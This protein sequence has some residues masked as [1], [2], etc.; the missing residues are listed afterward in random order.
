MRS[1]ARFPADCDRDADCRRRLGG[2]AVEA[3]TAL[4]NDP[5]IAAKFL[6]GRPKLFFGAL[7]N[8]PDSRALIPDVIAGARAGDWSKL[9]EARERLERFG[10]PFAAAQAASSIP[11]VS[12]ISASEN[13]ARPDLTRDMVA[14]EEGDL[15]FTSS[16]PTQL[17]GGAAM[18]YPRDAAFGVT[19]R[20]LPPF[21]VLQGDM[22]PKTPYAGALAH[23][24]RLSSAGAVRFVRVEGAPHFVLLTAEACAVEEILSFTASAGAGERICSQQAHDRRPLRNA[25]DRN[26]RAPHH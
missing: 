15:L 19:P 10:A 13:T 23:A 16:I 26:D 1:G 14:A 5:E 7:L 9:L 17:L 4:E 22:D 11:L 6:G 2:S 25:P 24:A 20:S 18:A 8:S 21:L 12:L 3:M